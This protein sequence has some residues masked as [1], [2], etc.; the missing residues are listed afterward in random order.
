M[1]TTMM[2]TTMTTTMT[3]PTRTEYVRYARR[4]EVAAIAVSR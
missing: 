1:T 3:R 2:T 4:V